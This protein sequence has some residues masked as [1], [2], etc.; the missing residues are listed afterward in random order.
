VSCSHDP[1]RDGGNLVAETARCALARDLPEATLRT[2]SRRPT[3]RPSAP[4]FTC[5]VAWAREAMQGGVNPRRIDSKDGV[6]GSIPAGA[7]HK[8]AAQAASSNRP[9]A[10]PRA[11]DPV[12]R[13]LPVRLMRSASVYAVCRATPRRPRRPV[14]LTREVVTAAV[15]EAE[16]TEAARPIPYT[17][18]H[19][20]RGCCRNPRLGYRT[21]ILC[22]TGGVPEGACRPRPRAPA[23]L[24]MS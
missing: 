13:E 24:E 22:A 6:A 19:G 1:A 8:P 15:A 11:G 2:T 23:C 16:C 4:P 17:C 5:A 14:D 18:G 3:P 7:L 20:A 12:A 10:R 9:A 21:A